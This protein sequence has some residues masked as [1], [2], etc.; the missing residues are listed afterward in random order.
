MPSVAVGDSQKT[1]SFCVA[2]FWCYEASLHLPARPLPAVR[3]PA[4]LSQPA[5]LR[6][7]ELRFSRPSSPHVFVGTAF[8]KLMWVAQNTNISFRFHIIIT[9]II[10]VIIIIE[11]AKSDHNS[12]SP[13]TAVFYIIFFPI[14]GLKVVSRC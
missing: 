1:C 3:E 2:L 6:E 10:I 4:A 13:K 5:E 11:Y 8:P 12:V 9:I 7:V 14:H